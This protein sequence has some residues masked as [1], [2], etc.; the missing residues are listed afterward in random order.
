[1]PQRETLFELE[2]DK[3]EKVRRAVNRQVLCCD[4]GHSRATFGSEEYT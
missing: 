2:T 1:M 3:A 4:L